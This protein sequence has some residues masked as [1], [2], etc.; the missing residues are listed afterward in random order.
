MKKKICQKLSLKQSVYP[1]KFM[2]VLT[3]FF[4]LLEPLVLPLGKEY[5]LNVIKEIVVTNDFL[6][7]DKD[8]TNCQNEETYDNCITR[9]FTNT[10]YEKCK[11]LPSSF[12]LSYE[13]QLI[14]K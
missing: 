8:V 12:T 7:L 5:N 9:K 6:G 3:T 4:T 2:I 11:C 10:M 1:K 14:L 13:V